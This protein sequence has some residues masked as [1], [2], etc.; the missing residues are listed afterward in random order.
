MSSRP[1]SNAPNVPPP[2]H[3]SRKRKSHHKAYDLPRERSPRRRAE[4]HLEL[5]VMH[6]T[7]HSWRTE[8]L[9]FNP[10]KL[11]DRELWMEIREIFR[12]DLQ[13]PWR[14]IFGFKKV[15]SIVPIGVSSQTMVPSKLV[16]PWTKLR[17]VVYAKRRSTPYRPERLSR[18]KTV[19][20]CLSSPRPSSA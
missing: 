13:K 20:A 8:P 6:G 7:T 15:T 5:C 16:E 11:D 9:R 3:S 2:P 1:A 18:L 12:Q 19:Y 17:T 10:D 14:R 4:I